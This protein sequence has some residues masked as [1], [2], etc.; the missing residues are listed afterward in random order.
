MHPKA[1]SEIPVN[2]ASSISVD[3]NGIPLYQTIKF[4]SGIYQSR[5]PLLYK[6]T[7][8][9]ILE[10]VNDWNVTGAPHIALSNLSNQ[11][12]PLCSNQLI[13]LHE[14]LSVRDVC[15]EICRSIEYC[16]QEP[17]TAVGASFPLHP[18]R[19]LLKSSKLNGER[20]QLSRVT[21]TVA[22][23]CTIEPSETQQPWASSARS[24]KNGGPSGNTLYICQP[25]RINH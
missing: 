1:A 5:Q 8:L 10:L 20:R 19:I 14:A 9:L 16:L 4:Y 22:D 17:H 7:L 12:G 15:S 25:S 3:E 21:R 2:P 23:L 13:L 18:M 11:E 24:E 6:T